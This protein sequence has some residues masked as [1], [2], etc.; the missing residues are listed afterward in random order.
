[1][2]EELTIL[3]LIGHFL[4]DY[5]FQTDKMAIQKELSFSVLCLHG[6]LYT[7]AMILAILPIYSFE[8]LKMTLII[9]AIHFVIDIV[10]YIFVVDEKYDNIMFMI[11]QVLHLTTIFSVVYFMK[12]SLVPVALHKSLIKFQLTNLYELL[13]NIL[14]IVF[15]M[16]PVS[17]IIRQVL[18]KYTPVNLERSDRG[19]ENAGSLIGILERLLI[20]TLLFL[21]Q[22]VVIGFVL[23]AKSIT[24]YDKITKDPQF[25]EYYL[26]GTLLSILIVVI[27]F[28]LI[29]YL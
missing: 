19:H 24:R 14:L 13:K 20:M 6:L 29:R 10:K 15:I 5:Y 1:M 28:Y 9:S 8:V 17:V 7:A 11:D 27:S 16:K 21:D 18:H 25:S 23:T 3:L 12:S 22:F 2:Y 4:G 26:L